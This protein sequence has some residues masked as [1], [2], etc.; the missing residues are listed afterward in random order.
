MLGPEYMPHL[1][2]LDLSGDSFLS[3]PSLATLSAVMT[4]LEVFHLGHF[5]HSDYSCSQT[6]IKGVGQSPLR[7]LYVCELLKD[8]TRFPKLQL[9]YMEI[10]CDLTHFIL[11]QMKEQGIRKGQ[12][13]VRFDRTKRNIEDKVD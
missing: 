10:A 2:E 7:G 3:K 11:Y 12:L 1:R 4:T 5:E 6:V 9:L 13:Q 8:P